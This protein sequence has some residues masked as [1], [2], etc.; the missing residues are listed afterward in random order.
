MEARRL[1]FILVV[2]SCSISAAV[3][4][5]EHQV[6]KEGCSRCCKGLS[7]SDSDAS[8]SADGEF[9]DGSCVCPDS[10]LGPQKPLEPE[11]DPT[12]KDRTSE[13]CSA[14]RTEMGCRNCCRN[15]HQDNQL[16][17]FISETFE[18]FKGGKCICP[19]GRES[20]DAYIGMSLVG[21]KFKQVTGP[22]AYYNPNKISGSDLMGLE[23]H[24]IGE[25][26]EN[27][28]VP[29]AIK[30]HETEGDFSGNDRGY[31]PP[32]SFISGRGNRGLSM[33]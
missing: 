8:L 19:G 31:S 12:C 5:C 30:S 1:I 16:A 11:E 22:D 28:L 2:L 33:M 23:R 32:H 13:D 9:K 26:E 21:P 7:Q 6:N 25:N 10:E 4:V 29:G 20:D 3:S 17:S 27:D 18:G 24:R 14:C 15:Y